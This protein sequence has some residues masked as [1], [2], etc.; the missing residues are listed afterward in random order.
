MS[1]NSSTPAGVTGN[2]PQQLNTAAGPQATSNR[3][4]SWVKNNKILTGVLALMAIY[5]FVS[6]FVSYGMGFG[7]LLVTLFLLRYAHK[8]Y[9]KNSKPTVV[10]LVGHLIAAIIA[11]TVINSNFVQKPLEMVNAANEELGEI[12]ARE[13]FIDCI[14]RDR[15]EADGYFT[16]RKGCADQSIETPTGFDPRF[17]IEDGRFPGAFGE[18]VTSAWDEHRGNTVNFTHNKWPEGVDEVV[19]RMVNVERAA[20]IDA[21]AEQAVLSDA[22]RAIEEARASQ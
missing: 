3:L 2:V 15:V 1:N 17:H 20:E 14:D 10:S 13:V 9:E 12:D 19:V 21:A 22:D 7:G 6:T 8:Q 4:K 11:L 18:W 5:T 16:L